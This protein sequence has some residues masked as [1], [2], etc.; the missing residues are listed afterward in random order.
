MSIYKFEQDK[1][2]ITPITRTT[3]AEQD[4]QEIKH[5]QSC[6]KSQIDAISPGTLV[7]S[8]EFQFNNWKDSNR[9]IDLLGIDKDAN[10]VVVELKRTEDGGHMELQALR[11][12]AMI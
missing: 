10:F 3:F 7:I 12:A 6:L 1:N 5:L 4:M 8:S 11:Y 2:K 9:R